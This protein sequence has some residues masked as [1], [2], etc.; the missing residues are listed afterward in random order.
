MA[1]QSHAVFW[2]R[3]SRASIQNQIDIKLKGFSDTKNNVLL[4]YVKK[5]ISASL[6][7]GYLSNKHIGGIDIDIDINVITD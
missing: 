7:F 2:F 3:D 4:C 6:F 1:V 5:S